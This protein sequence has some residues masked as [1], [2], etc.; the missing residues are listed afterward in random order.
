MRLVKCIRYFIYAI[1]LR[2]VRAE[3]ETNS[4]RPFADSASPCSC[5]IDPKIFDRG[6]QVCARPAQFLLF[7]ACAAF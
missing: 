1:L 4:E 5:L 6:W 3:K 7:Q 2:D